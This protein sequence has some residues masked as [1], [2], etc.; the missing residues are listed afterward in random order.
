MYSNVHTRRQRE[1]SPVAVSAYLT[2]ERCSSI[3]FSF[4]IILRKASCD[5]LNWFHFI[6]CYFSNTAQTQWSDGRALLSVAESCRS[7]ESTQDDRKKPEFQGV[8]LPVQAVGSFCWHS[9]LRQFSFRWK[10]VIWPFGT[11]GYVFG[12]GKERDKGLSVSPKHWHLQRM[13][14]SSCLLCWLWILGELVHSRSVCSMAGGGSFLPWW[15][16]TVRTACL[17]RATG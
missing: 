17:N 11:S 6:N 15:W 10:L 8:H 9:D 16:W 4:Y 3:F 5:A 14:G 7:S 13:T 12:N 1:K 2:A